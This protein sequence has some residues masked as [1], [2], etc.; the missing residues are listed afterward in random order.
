MSNPEQPTTPETPNPEATAQQPTLLPPAS[1]LPQSAPLVTDP[2]AAPAAPA[3][4]AATQ[5]FPP[6]DPNAATQAFPPAPP[7]APMT[8]APAAPGA[9]VPPQPVAYGAPQAGGP[10]APMNTLAIVSLVG[11]FFISL[12]GIICGH[13]ALKQIKRDGTRGRGLALAG[14]IIGYVALAAQIITGIFLVIALIAGAGALNAASSEFDQQLQDSGSSLVEEDST[15]GE[16][17][18]PS[19][20]GAANSEFCSTFNELGT[21]APE[22]LAEMSAAYQK[23]ADNAPTPEGAKIYEQ[24]AKFTTDPAAAMQDPNFNLETFTEEATSVMMNDAMSCM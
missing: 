15:T 18:E 22:N 12:V 6:V 3:A 23:L 21:I 5:A 13:I 17:T 1:E 7:A 24:F 16:T 10:Q 9:P 11:S 2:L 19:T 8:G 14:T 4:P 20:G